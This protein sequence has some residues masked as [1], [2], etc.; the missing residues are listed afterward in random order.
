MENDVRLYF[1]QYITMTQGDSAKLRRVAKQ[2]HRAGITNM[3]TLSNM[4]LKKPER[5]RACRNIGKKSM[6]L[7]DEVCK[8]YRKQ[9]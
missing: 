8:N 5:I 2:L 6:V 4:I 3:E 9:L 7:I 1:Q